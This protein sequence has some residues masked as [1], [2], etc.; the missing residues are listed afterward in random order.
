ERIVHT[1][2]DFG[3]LDDLVFDEQALHRGAKALRDKAPLIVDVTMVA[4]GIT[5]YDSVCLLSEVDT[6][7]GA[8]RSAAAF[9]LAAQRYP[10]G[11]VWVVGNAPTALFELL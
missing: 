7:A 11:A 2:A 3:W 6:S 5:K 9:R 1:T 10:R 4:A 8:T